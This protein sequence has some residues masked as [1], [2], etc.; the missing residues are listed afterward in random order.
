MTISTMPADRATDPAAAP[1]HGGVR[2]STICATAAEPASAKTG[3]PATRW[4]VVWNRSPRAAGPAT[5]TGRRS[6]TRTSRRARRGRRDGAP[7][8]ERSATA[9]S[10]AGASA[11]RR[12]RASARRRRRRSRRAR[13]ARHRAARAGRA[14]TPRRPPRRARRG[15]GRRRSPRRWSG[16]RR[17]GR[18]GRGGRA[19]RRWL[20]RGAAPVASPCTPRATKSQMTESATM[21]RTVAPMSA[22]RATSRTGGGR[23]RPT[24]GRRAGAQPG[25]R[26][27]RWRTRA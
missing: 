5:G 9:G 1:A 3:T 11:T 15:P 8:A 4:L 14:G 21:K 22:L 20:R 18:G 16:P 25:R 26:S 12:A 10:A 13:T 27:R 17:P 19:A 7:R 24:R 6:T 23:P 2:P